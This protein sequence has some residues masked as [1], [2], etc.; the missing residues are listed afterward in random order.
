MFFKFLDSNSISIAAGMFQNPTNL[1][2]KMN[3][4]VEGKLDYYKLDNQLPKRKR[5]EK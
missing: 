5:Y 3:I 4:F 1:K 2:T